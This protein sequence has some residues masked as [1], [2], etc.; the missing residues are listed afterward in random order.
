MKRHCGKLLSNR[1]W[2]RMDAD[3]GKTRPL[4]AASARFSFSAQRENP[5]LAEDIASYQSHSPPRR[6]Q[7]W[8]CETGHRPVQI[9]NRYLRPRLFLAPPQGLQELHHADQPA[10]MVDRQTRRQRRTRQ[11]PPTRAAQTRLAKHHCVGVPDREAQD[12]RKTWQ[13]AREA[14]SLTVRAGTIT[15][16]AK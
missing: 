5:R 10:E 1:R 12:T 9:Q 6:G 13:A 8:V 3:A 11:S 4:A 2:T 14:A 16:S 7:G 15:V